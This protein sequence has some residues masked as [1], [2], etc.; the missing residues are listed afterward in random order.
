MRREERLAR[1]EDDGEPDGRELRLRDRLR[2]TQ[3]DLRQTRE[4]LREARLR[5]TD[6]VLRRDADRVVVRREGQII[7]LNTEDTTRFGGDEFVERLPDGRTQTIVVRPGNVRIVTIRSNDGEILRRSRV[8]PNGREYVLIDAGEVPERVPMQ[9]EPELPPLILDIPQEEYIVE[10]EA[11]TEQEIETALAA[12]PVE[13]VERV[14]TLEEVRQNERVRAKVRRIDLDT[15]TFDFGSAEIPE[16]QL[17]TLE[18]VGIALEELVFNQPNELFLIEGHTDA[19]GSNIA[20]L[21]LSD[22]RAEAVALALAGNFDIPPE[23]LVTQGYG[24]EDLKVPTLGPERENRRVT[25][26]R[27]TELV[28]AEAQEEVR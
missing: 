2:A 14:Y 28:N 15:I 23:N 18:E 13:E 7:I 8:L 19:V 26:R 17:I 16:T 6:E 24:E 21:E 20:N 25:I 10:T 5:E 1:L 3:D 12:P 22:R 11:A 9:L 27:I 4:Q